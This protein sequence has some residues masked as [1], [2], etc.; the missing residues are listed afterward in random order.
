MSRSDKLLLELT[1][2]YSKL[3]KGIW[4]YFIFCGTHQC[5]TSKPNVDEALRAEQSSWDC[6]A[7]QEVAIFVIAK[8]TALLRSSRI[9][10][11]QQSS[12]STAGIPHR[13]AVKSLN[14]L[15][16]PPIRRPMN[17]KFIS[18][19]SIFK[20]NFGREA[21]V[22]NAYNPPLLKPI[23]QQIF[24]SASNPLRCAATDS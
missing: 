19:F 12:F 17:W 5:V 2:G 16:L 22:F 8:G 21:W 13:L 4:V 15:R 9:I 1:R 11:G 23:A 6:W 14:R 7:M 24:R 18:C 3:C 20:Q 10:W